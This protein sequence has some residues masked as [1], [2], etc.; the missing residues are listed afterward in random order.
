VHQ[1]VIQ[2]NSTRYRRLHRV[3]DTTVV[4]G[5]RVHCCPCSS[6]KRYVY[7]PRLGDELGKIQ[8]VIDGRIIFTHKPPS[9]GQGK[10]EIQIKYQSLNPA[11][12]FRA[13]VDAARS[14]ILAGG[15]MSPVGDSFFDACLLSGLFINPQQMSDLTNQ[16]FAHLPSSR[17]ALFSC[18]HITPDANLRTL[19]LPRGPQGTE[20]NFK[21]SNM[22]NR[23]LVKLHPNWCSILELIRL[24]VIRTWTNR[25]QLC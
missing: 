18:D 20:L 19:V 6:Y 1:C 3:R 9:H 16:L 12:Q 17:I 13:V 11:P 8:V 25:G 23:D 2:L 24:I 15:T 5:S 22:E 10:P 7:A 4:C 14:V 21:F